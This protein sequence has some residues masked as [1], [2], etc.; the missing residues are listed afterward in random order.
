MAPLPSQCAKG[1]TIVLKC[2]IFGPRFQQDSEINMWST[3]CYLPT[4]ARH[5]AAPH[6]QI[7]DLKIALWEKHRCY[8]LSPDLEVAN[9]ENPEDYG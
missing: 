9:H 2:L 6:Q 7:A 5:V 1:Y 3:V 8:K 4:C